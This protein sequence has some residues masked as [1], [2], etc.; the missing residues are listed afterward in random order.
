MFERIKLGIL[1][2]KIAVEH[3]RT[4]KTMVLVCEVEGDP[5]EISDMSTELVESSPEA[6]VVVNRKIIRGN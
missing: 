1:A 5:G 2:N 4:G 3:K 6:I